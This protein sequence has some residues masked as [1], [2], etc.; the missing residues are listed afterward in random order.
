MDEILPSKLLEN[1]F[2]LLFR[3]VPAW[4]R[5]PSGLTGMSSVA[6]PLYITAKHRS[7]LNFPAVRSDHP[8]A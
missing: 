2:V 8:P 3:T 6:V 4:L 5:S 1:L 7:C